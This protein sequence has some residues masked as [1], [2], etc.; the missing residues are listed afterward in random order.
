MFI[1]AQFKRAK[2][3]K[4]R[5]CPSANEWINNLWSI[6]TM[7]FCAAEQKKELIPFPTACMELENIILSAIRQVVRDKFLM[8][9]PLTGTQSTQEKSNQNI[10][11]DSEVGN[12]LTIDSEEW[13]GDSE[14]RGLQELV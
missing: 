6:C 14:E 4:Q 8:I 5:N 3:W 10:T 7:E 11:R 2:Y 12:S 9:S 13:E 1:A